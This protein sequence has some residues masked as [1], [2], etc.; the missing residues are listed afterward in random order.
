MPKVE[1]SRVEKIF[2]GAVFKCT[3]T[4]VQYWTNV[5]S[6]SQPLCTSLLN[7]LRLGPCIQIIFLIQIKGLSLIIF[8]AQMSI[9]MLVCFMH[10]IISLVPFPYPSDAHLLFMSQLLI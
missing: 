4:Y 3:L 2:L 1:N 7:H 10:N 6:L 8:G 9:M 5:L